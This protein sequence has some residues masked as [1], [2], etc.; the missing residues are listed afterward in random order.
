MAT[1]RFYLV[2]DVVPVEETPEHEE[3]A[4]APVVFRHGLKRLQKN[5]LQR[6]RGVHPLQQLFEAGCFPVVPY[7]AVHDRLAAVLQK[8]K[9]MEY[10]IRLRLPRFNRTSQFNRSFP[11][12]AR[13]K[14]LHCPL[15]EDA[16]EDGGCGKKVFFSL[17]QDPAS[18]N[19][20]FTGV[21][22]YHPELS[23]SEGSML[24]VGVFWLAA[25]S[26]QERQFHFN[27]RRQDGK[28]LKNALDYVFFVITYGITKKTEVLLC[29]LR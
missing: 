17:H 28:R 16:A 10:R 21:Y 2:G 23:K 4:V 7:C 14:A 3:Q 18:M 25:R 12:I 11:A 6:C 13:K 15:P 19:D 8:Q 22:I 20:R 5:G 9:T 29:V 27:T 26:S 24:T 1:T